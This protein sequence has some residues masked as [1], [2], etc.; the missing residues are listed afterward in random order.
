MCKLNNEC[1]EQCQ[2][3]PFK[4]QETFASVRLK[5]RALQQENVKMFVQYPSYAC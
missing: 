1:L 2:L 5:W 3:S 4:S